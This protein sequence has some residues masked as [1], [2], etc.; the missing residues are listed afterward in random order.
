MSFEDEKPR[1]FRAG[2]PRLS[3]L[4]VPTVTPNILCLH[5]HVLHG[6]SR[7]SA[8]SVDPRVLCEVRVGHAWSLPAPTFGHSRLLLLVTEVNVYCWERSGH[9]GLRLLSVN[10]YENT[11]VCIILC[12]VGSRI[13]RSQRRVRTWAAV[14]RET[15]YLTFTRMRNATKTKHSL[16]NLNCENTMAIASLCRT[17]PPRRLT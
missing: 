2:A 5:W 15:T 3:E 17:L 6:G 9:N 16:T 4:G 7:N 1:Q 10:C 13:T 14:D 12:T 8:F 11:V